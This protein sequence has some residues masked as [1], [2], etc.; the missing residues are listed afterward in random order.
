[1]RSN[2]TTFE[3]VEGLSHDE[4]AEGRIKITTDELLAE[5]ADVSELLG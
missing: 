3:T 2:G 5:K 4:F 1:V